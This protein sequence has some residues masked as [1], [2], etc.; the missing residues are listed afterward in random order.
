MR[1]RTIIF[2]AAVAS[3]AALIAGGVYHLIA[4]TAPDSAG[5]SAPITA[6]A[7][8]GAEGERAFSLHEQ[9][10]P[11]PA[12]QFVD[13]AGHAMTLAD[14][15]GKTVL[16]NLWATWCVPCREEMPAL[17]RLQAKL[18][19]PEFEVIPLSI[20]RGGLATVET[21]YQELGLTALAV[22]VD[23]SGKAAQQ[24]RAVGIP[25]TLLINRE[26]QEVGR[27]VGPAEWDA[28]AA[29]AVI[30]NLLRTRPDSVRA[31]HHDREELPNAKEAHSPRPP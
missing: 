14:F 27:L 22:Y 17:D 19:S 1:S 7:A 30:R 26:G 13:G 5:A 10:E 8:G 21:F 23:D 12:L 16:L 15:S 11:V 25:T 3:A 20:D 18:G 31:H 2:T 4:T 6:S 24:L 9:P 28:P 29:V